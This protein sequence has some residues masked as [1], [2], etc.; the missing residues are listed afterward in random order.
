MSF[1]ANFC[2][3]PSPVNEYAEQLIRHIEDVD[4]KAREIA[5][6]QRKVI[7]DALKSEE[8]EVIEYLE[9][10]YTACKYNN[11]PKALKV[12][13]VGLPCRPSQTNMMIK[14][15]NDEI[16]KT[17]SEIEEWV[18][19][20]DEEADSEVEERADEGDEEG[21]LGKRKVSSSPEPERKKIC[22]RPSE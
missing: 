20:D 2:P 17:D 8:K 11:Y 15:E 5:R 19:E 9:D 14:M 4:N 13:N 21:L 6:E 10:R 18:D 1:N 12:L 16:Y 7:E 3:S 22:C